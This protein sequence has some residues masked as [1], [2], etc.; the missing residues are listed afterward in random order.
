MTKSLVIDT[1]SHISD[2]LCRWRKW[3]VTKGI[4]WPE[5][6]KNRLDP[7]LELDEGNAFSVSSFLLGRGDVLWLQLEVL[8]TTTWKHVGV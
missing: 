5:D 3:F 7:S 4:H 2:S 1:F 8:R 6:Y